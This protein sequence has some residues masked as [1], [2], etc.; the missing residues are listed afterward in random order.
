LLVSSWVPSNTVQF[1]GE[2]RGIFSIHFLAD[3]PATNAA[4]PLL[5]FPF[6]N[7]R[8]AGFTSV[9]GFSSGLYKTK[10]SE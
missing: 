3:G 1:L 4:N 9:S 7:K 10:R 8:E 2:Q 6:Q 5:T